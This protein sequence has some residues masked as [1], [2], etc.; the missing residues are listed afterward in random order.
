MKRS[1]KKMLEKQKNYFSLLCK[2]IARRHNIKKVTKITQS[3]ASL[4]NLIAP[5]S[6]SRKVSTSLAVL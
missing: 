2:K 3:P 5:R 4:K 6:S 1:K